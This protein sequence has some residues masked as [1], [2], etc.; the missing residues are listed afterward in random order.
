MSNPEFWDMFLPLFFDEEKL[1]EFATITG[2]TEQRIRAA[3][4]EH[5]RNVAPHFHRSNGTIN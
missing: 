4:D 5:A 2:L 3:R 1:R